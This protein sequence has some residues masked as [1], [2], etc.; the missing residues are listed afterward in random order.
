MMT[1]AQLA[2]ISII[3]ITVN[4]MSV[5]VLAAVRCGEQKLQMLE[6]ENNQPARNF[7]TKGDEFFFLSLLRIILPGGSCLYS[8][9]HKLC[10]FFSQ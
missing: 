9:F 7:Q 2:D 1:T 10:M 5:T 4:D 6:T 8:L 3:L